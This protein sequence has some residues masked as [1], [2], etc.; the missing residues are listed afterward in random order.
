MN[1]KK[2][3]LIIIV[4][5]AFLSISCASTKQTQIEHK[6][7]KTFLA[8][9]NSSHFEEAAALPFESWNVVN[10]RRKLIPQDNLLKGT[11]NIF[12]VHKWDE[13]ELLLIMSQD[14][15]NCDQ[16][17]TWLVLLPE[18]IWTLL[19][20]DISMDLCTKGNRYSDVTE[21]GIDLYWCNDSIH[22][23]I[24]IN[25]NG[26]ACTSYYLYIWNREDNVYKFYDK[27]CG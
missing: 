6:S 13:N 4:L 3:N 19:D 17:R 12:S 11:E 1:P 27:K 15:E 24:E 7:E 2:H 22:P 26:P 18:N 21:S 8:W 14:N 20:K 10:D 9:W 5:I 23:I 25:T 16:Q